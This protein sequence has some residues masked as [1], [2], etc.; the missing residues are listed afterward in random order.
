[1]GLDLR[2]HLQSGLIDTSHRVYRAVLDWE[3]N[4]EMPL[5]QGAVVEEWDGWSSIGT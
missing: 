2:I 5:F 4:L 3:A 1:M